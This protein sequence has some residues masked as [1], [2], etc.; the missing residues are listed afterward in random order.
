MNIYLTRLISLRNLNSKRIERLFEIIG[1]FG[2]LVERVDGVKIQF[3][4]R[5][6]FENSGN[7]IIV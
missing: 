4:E 6:I 1:F 5:P 3:N 7:C 2:L